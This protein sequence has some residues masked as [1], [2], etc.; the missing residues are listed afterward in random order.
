M[1]EE[2]RFRQDLLPS[3]DGASGNDSATF[4][5]DRLDFEFWITCERKLVVIKNN[6]NIEKEEGRTGHGKEKDG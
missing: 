4:A 2:R 3:S 6:N 5:R 1:G